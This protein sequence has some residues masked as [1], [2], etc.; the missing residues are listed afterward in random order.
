MSIKTLER[1]CT[2]HISGR[3]E[4]YTFK[5]Q[6][7]EIPVPSGHKIH[8]NE[9]IRAFESCQLNPEQQATL[10]QF[11]LHFN[12]Q[13]Y[14]VCA[15]AADVMVLLTL[16]KDENLEQTLKNY[17]LRSEKMI[18]GTFVLSFTSPDR[19]EFETT[20][21]AFEYQ[22]TPVEIKYHHVFN[23]DKNSFSFSNNN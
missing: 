22:S 9:Y 13:Q 1:L 11:F 16:L 12:G 18:R 14:P 10:K 3:M 23:Y 7:N 15:K 17:N 21:T 2:T 20:Y 4:P 6:D 8:I 19:L 5:M